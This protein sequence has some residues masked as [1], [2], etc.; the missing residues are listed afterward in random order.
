MSSYPSFFIAGTDTGVGKTRVAC[1]ILCQL[2]AKGINAAGAKPIASGMKETNGK[3]LNEDIQA[4]REAT[5]RQFSLDLVNQYRYEPYIAPHIAAM[6]RGE[7]IDTRT[8]QDCFYRLAACSDLVVVEG[9]GGLMTPINE[10]QTFLDLIQLLNLPVV[11]V[12]A[13]RLGCINHALL[14]QWALE[15][16]GVPLLAWVANYAAAGAV[17]DVVVEASLVNRLNAPLLGVIPW[18]SA[19]TNAEALDLDQLIS[20]H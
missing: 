3:W 16:A 20:A 15:S 1:Q 12:V 8:I 6:N 9:A 17:R 14:S 7:E 10:A 4:I 11:L 19:L 5:E 2:R 18:S 13:I